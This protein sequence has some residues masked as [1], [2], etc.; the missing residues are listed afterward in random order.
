MNPEEIMSLNEKK[1][2]SISFTHELP[3]MDFQNYIKFP[4]FHQ[5]KKTFCFF[6]FKITYF[7]YI[8]F[9]LMFLS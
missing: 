2:K 3:E 9:L 5:E 8:F 1:K 4:V 7:G 6:V